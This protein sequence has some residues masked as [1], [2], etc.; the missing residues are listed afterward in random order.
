MT[1]KYCVNCKWSEQDQERSWTLRCKHP[2]V[3]CKD[4]YSLSSPTIRGKDC[5]EE[6]RITGFFFVACGLRGRLYEAK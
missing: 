1:L 2:K 6:R 4:A 5:T 3:N